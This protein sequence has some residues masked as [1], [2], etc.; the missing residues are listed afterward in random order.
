MDFLDKAFIFE[1]VCSG[2]FSPSF[3]GG[4]GDPLLIWPREDR[5]PDR[6][7]IAENVATTTAEKLDTHHG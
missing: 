2:S 4:S 3:L 5:L 1:S 6:G 7:I